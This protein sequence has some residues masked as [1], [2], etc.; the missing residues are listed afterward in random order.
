MFDDG[1]VSLFGPTKPKTKPL[2]PELAAEAAP[3]RRGSLPPPATAS[4]LFGDAEPSAAPI[5]LLAGTKPKPASSDLFGDTPPLLE[6]A[7]PRISSGA[8]TDSAA[9]FAEAAPKSGKGVLPHAAP[10]DLFGES[11]RA[12][13]GRN[14]LY[15]G[16]PKASRGGGKTADVF[17]EGGR[18]PA[19]EAGALFTED[20]FAQPKKAAKAAVVQRNADVPATQPEEAKKKPQRDIFEDEEDVLTRPKAQKKPADQNDDLF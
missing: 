4:D 1:E 17:Q 5:D 20:A 3:V 18:K 10:E 11:P 6:P 7:L 16:L 12:P 9:L 15:Q 19:P 2:P 8:R 13:S 14:L